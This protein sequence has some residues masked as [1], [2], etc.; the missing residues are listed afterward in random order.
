MRVFK[1]ALSKS[2]LQST[3]PIR[4]K[5]QKI[6]KVHDQW[7]LLRR[8]GHPSKFIPQNSQSTCATPSMHTGGPRQ[9]IVKAVPTY[10]RWTLRSKKNLACGAGPLLCS[11]NVLVKLLTSLSP[12]C[13]PIG[14]T[15][16]RLLT[17][18]PAPLSISRGKLHGDRHH[19]VREDQGRQPHS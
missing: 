5:N 4:M 19:G 8:S 9:L 11:L 15:R 16:L 6:S 3:K 1:D 13:L 14:T 2:L 10:Q 12:S 17:H 18:L 7:E